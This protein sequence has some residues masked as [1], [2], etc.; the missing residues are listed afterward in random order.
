MEQYHVIGMTCAACS[1]HVEKAVKAVD[2]VTSVTVSLLTNAMSVE[3]S[4]SPQAVIAAVEK[5]GYGASL[6]GAAQEESASAADLEDHETPKLK[7][8]LIASLCLL[9]PL[10]YLTMGHMMWNWPVPEAL[11]GNH[12]AMGLIELLLTGMVMVINQ[13]FFISGFTSLIHRA[14]NMDTLVALGAT[15]AFVYST[16]SLFAMTG[17]QVA[18]DMDGV[19]KWMDEFYFVSAA[20]ILTLITVGKMLEAR[21]KGKTTDA[22]KTLMNLSPQTATLLVDGQEQVVPIGQV[23]QG[24]VFVVRSGDSIPVDGVI[25]EGTCAVDESALTGESIPVDKAPGAKV[26]AVPSHSGGQGHHPVPDH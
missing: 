14:P 15:A 1:A 25:L 12:V 5:A 7:K 6:A 3:G 4:A 19:M 24:D 21:S 10:M 20:M 9:V 11:A 16:Y 8:R 2:G 17:A 13:K 22:L 23:S 26:S 18:G